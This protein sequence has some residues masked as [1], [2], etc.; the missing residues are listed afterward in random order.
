MALKICHNCVHTIPNESVFCPHCGQKYSTKLP[1]FLELIRS[2]LSNIFGLDNRLFNTLRYLFIPAQLPIKYIQGKRKSIIPPGQLFLGLSIVFF[3][4]LFF[5]K[6]LKEMGIGDGLSSSRQY[7][8]TVEYLE[9][10]DKESLT[11]EQKSTLNGSLEV[12]KDNLENDADSFD[13]NMMWLHPTVKIAHRDLHNLSPEELFKTYNLDFNLVQSIVAK[14]IL[15][16]QEDP[17][18]MAKFMISHAYWIVFLSI[19]FMAF[20]LKLLYTR[21]NRYYI[22]HVVFLLYTHSSLLILFL[23]LYFINLIVEVNNWFFVL[24]LTGFVILSQIY[25]YRQGVM[26][27]LLKIFLFILTYPFILV[28][29]LLIIFGISVF[30]F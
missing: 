24:T 1:S 20:I 23:L 27:S 16:I 17:D 28:L 10:L 9:N 3:T 29:S 22:E 15:R 6:N 13:L 4:I 25:Y 21:R 18:E 30:I 19:P 26:K 12:I 2:A 8:Y 14:R 5:N 11:T 7:L